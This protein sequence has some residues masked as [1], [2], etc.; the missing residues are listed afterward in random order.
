MDKWHDPGS[1]VSS[2]WSWQKK[3]IFL[4]LPV[5]FHSR[6]DFLSRR[7]SSPSNSITQHPDH[8]SHWHLLVFLKFSQ[9]QNDFPPCHQLLLIPSEV[10]PHPF[11]HSFG[12]IPRLGSCFPGRH[13]DSRTV[14]TLTIH[15]L[16][17][18]TVDSSSI[19]ELH[20]GGWQL[21]SA[22]RF[23]TIYKWSGEE[24]E[25]IR[26]QAL[27]HQMDDRTGCYISLKVVEINRTA[28]GN[29]DYKLLHVR[30][31]KRIRDRCH[32]GIRV[33][34]IRWK[35][36]DWNHWI[37]CCS[38]YWSTDWFCWIVCCQTWS[39]GAGDRDQNVVNFNVSSCQGKE[40]RTLCGSATSFNLQG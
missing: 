5:F 35:F 13:L 23:H 6:A 11:H 10:D 2:P 22:T 25:I 36:R 1:Q 4:L 30:W 26:T 27:H 12:Q 29:N 33:K 24:D 28:W 40:C 37:V 20:H 9:A 16:S 8:H 38:L 14:N 7:L 34:F 3:M 31:S 39:S 32:S 15:N 17:L 18:Q 19:L 21:F